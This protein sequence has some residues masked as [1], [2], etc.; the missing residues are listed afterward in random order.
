ML[1]SWMKWKKIARLTKDVQR[2]IT[3]VSILRIDVPL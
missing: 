1:L 2:C 3:D